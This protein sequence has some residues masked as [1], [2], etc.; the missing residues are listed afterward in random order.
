MAASALA[1]ARAVIHRLVHNA[2]A[3]FLFG[4]GRA[5]HGGCVV[6]RTS[7]EE[8]VPGCLLRRFASSAD[9]GSC[10]YHGDRPICCILPFIDEGDRDRPFCSIRPFIDEGDRDPTTTSA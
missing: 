3:A 8:L 2:A 7:A 5:R 1:A 4:M 6:P 10:V 9:R